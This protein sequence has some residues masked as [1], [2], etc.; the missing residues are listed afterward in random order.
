VTDAIRPGR[1]D[2]AIHGLDAYGAGGLWK[3]AAV[4][5]KADGQ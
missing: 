2:I 5:I 3:P 1:N 4:M